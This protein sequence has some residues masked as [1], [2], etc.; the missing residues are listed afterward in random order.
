[1]ISPE[2]LRRYPF[3]QCLND[4]QQKAV[5]MITDEVA[6]SKGSVICQDGRPAGCLYHV[7][8]RSGRPVCIPGRGEEGK[9]TK[10]ITVADINPVSP[11]A[12]LSVPPERDVHLATRARPR[13]TVAC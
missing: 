3:F 5:A 10:Q 4:A 7:A 12:S 2:M 9:P 13:P 11:S 1:M 6:Y 8:G